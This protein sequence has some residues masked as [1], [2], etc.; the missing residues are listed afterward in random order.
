MRVFQDGQGR[1]WVATVRRR[2][3]NDYKGRYYFFL[4]PRGAEDAEGVALIDIRWNSERSAERALETISDVEL[5]RR[6]RSGVGRQRP[7][8]AIGA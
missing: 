5:R 1:H 6:L 4:S 2:P 3:G 7:A 8:Q